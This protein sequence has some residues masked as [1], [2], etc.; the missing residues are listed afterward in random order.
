MHIAKYL[1]MVGNDEQ[2]LAEAFLM[3]SDRHYREAD[4]GD[5]CKALAQWSRAHI[6]ALQPIIARYGEESVAD[7]DRLRASLFHGARVGGLGLVRDLQDLSALA[8]HLRL[9]WTA[10]YQASKS[11][12][13][14]E[15]EATSEHCGHEVDR[16]IEW[17]CTRLKHAAPQALVVRAEKDDEI[18]ESLVLKPQTLPGL[19]ESIWGPAAVAGMIAAVAV[20]AVLAGQQPWLVPS[21]GPTAYLAAENPAHPTSRL[22]N[23][24]IGHFVGLAMG[25]LA[26]FL[27][28]AN[29]DPGV[30][31]DHRLVPARALAAV[32]AMVLTI[33]IAPV[34]RA[35]HPPA[36]ATTLLV[37]LGA[38]RTM[39]D[40]I[41]VMIG[42]LI[43][44]V[45]AELLR[46]V[47]LGDFRIDPKK[48][49]ERRPAPL[50][51]SPR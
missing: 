17:I 3:M 43:I 11:L 50:P 44:A 49:E 47:R 20:I 14:K 27:L 19:P 39:N 51:W 8:N 31:S 12:H 42:V 32:L 35:S 21:L 24:V 4:V 22:F 7:P 10:L 48:T 38:L 40:A 5:M 2:E 26:V 25:F 41:S 23:T 16:Q 6:T 1:G 29:N 30:L 15:L 34:L 37:A 36:G 13:D 28:G 18:V 9:G 46:R 33:M 45:A